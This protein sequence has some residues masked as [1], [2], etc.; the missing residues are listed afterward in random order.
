MPDRRP[1]GSRT[2]ADE[3][4]VQATDDVLADI[5]WRMVKHRERVVVPSRRLAGDTHRYSTTAKRRT[6]VRPAGW[7]SATTATIRPRREPR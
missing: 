7:T 1:S 3:G 5:T 4:E 6:I 2:A